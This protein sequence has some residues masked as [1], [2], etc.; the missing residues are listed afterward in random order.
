MSGPADRWRGI[1]P[2]QNT[3]GYIPWE[4]EDYNCAPA[5]FQGATVR[6][7]ERTLRVITDVPPNW[8]GTEP[9]RQ[10]EL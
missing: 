8:K 4:H 1:D 10:A 3:S 9:D 2:L 7:E 5:G 6:E